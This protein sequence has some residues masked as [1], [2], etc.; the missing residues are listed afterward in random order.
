MKLLLISQYFW[1]ENFR[2]NDLAAELVKRGHEVTVLTG[3]PNYPQGEIFPEYAADKANF[4]S[5]GGA[6]VVRVPLRPRYRGNLNLALNYLSFALSG[7]FWGPIKLRGRRFEA[8]FVYEPSPVTVGIPA[9]VLKRIKRAPIAFWILDLWPQSL[10]A[11]GAVRSPAILG[12]IDALV[13]LLYRGFDLILVQSQSFVREV[14][15]QADGEDRIRYFPSWSDDVPS[16]EPVV[17]APEVPLANGRFTIMFTGN[18]GQAQ[19]FPSILDAAELLRH[20]PIRWVVVGDGRKSDWLAREVQTR[21]LTNSVLLLGRHQLERMRSFLAHA[22]ATLVALR[23]EPA[24]ALTIPGKVQAYLA[25]GK[26]MLAMIDG[27]GGDVIRAARA[28]FVAPAGDAAALAAAVRR[29]L[30]AT[31]EERL[32]MGRSGQAY[33]HSEFDREIVIDRLEG[34]LSDLAARHTK[35]KSRTQG[36]VDHTGRRIE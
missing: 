1:P 10:Q 18:V 9:I 19:D 33:A 28:G 31:P 7:S 8:I 23:P 25:A 29:M 14:A 6:Q 34:W 4:V 13:R 16:E 11:V 5:Y 35:D 17:P 22:D 30:A 15:R 27:E 32:E 36:Q 12:A 20:E 24:F 3:E 26:P 21:G 2:I